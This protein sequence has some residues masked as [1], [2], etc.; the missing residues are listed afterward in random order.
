MRIKKDFVTNSSS[1]SF[2][3]VDK[4]TGEILK[5]MAKVVWNDRGYDSKSKVDI[6][7]LLRNPKFDGSVVFPLTTNEETFIYRICPAKV[8]VDT[9][10]NHDWRKLPFERVSCKEWGKDYEK[11]MERPFL[12]M[13]DF[14]T[15]TRR[16]IFQERETEAEKEYLKYRK[17]TEERKK[18]ENQKRLHYKQ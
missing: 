12:D 1:T 7:Y 2:V 4:T 8:R 15:K 14:K 18:N 17:E 16:D 6:D 3:V 13:K 11:S 9:S 10:F 5:E